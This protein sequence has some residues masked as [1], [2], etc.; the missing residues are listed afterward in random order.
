LGDAVIQVCQPRWP[1][2][3][4]GQRF[5]LEELPRLVVETGRAGWLYRVL[6]PGAVAPADKLHRI[7][8]A[9]DGINLA[10]LWRLQEQRRPPLE[11]I[12][13]LAGM[14][15]LASAWRERFAKRLDWLRENS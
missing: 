3:K 12:E 8:Q 5:Q 4:L 2:W 15:T 9:R 6:E 1:C 14:Q 13:R 7:E 10:E 11:A